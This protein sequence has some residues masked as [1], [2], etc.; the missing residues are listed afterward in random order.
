MPFPEFDFCLICEGI[1]PEIGNK[2]TILGFYGVAPNVE[3]VIGN[4]AMPVTIAF[5]AGFPSVPDLRPAYEHSIVVNKPDDTV[6]LRTPASRLNPG[7]P[8]GRGLVVF[9]FVIPPPYAF[10]LYTIRIL[11]NNETKLRTS[12]R[13]R[14]ANPA[15]LG[16]V[17][18]P[19]PASGPP[20]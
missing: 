19:P 4:T 8:G 5:V 14:P 20:N 18:Q 1:R 13:L 12:F 9:G 11:V 10:G 3:I 2:L 7:V 6:L 17:F 16:A 15:E